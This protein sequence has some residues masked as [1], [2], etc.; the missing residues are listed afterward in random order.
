MMSPGTISTDYIP[1]KRERTFHI[2][3]LAV[4]HQEILQ[5]DKSSRFEAPRMSALTAYNTATVC[6][7]VRTHAA[8]SSTN[9]TAQSSMSS[10]PK[11]YA[12]AVTESGAGYRC[13]TEDCKRNLKAG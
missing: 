11:K 2:P 10:A 12:D 4:R 3:L 6:D 1:K 7:V 13:S 5:S 9:S 8:V